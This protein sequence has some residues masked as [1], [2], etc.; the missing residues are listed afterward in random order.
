M[1]LTILLL[2]QQS[3][4][5]GAERVLDEVLYALEPDS[6]PIV[7]FPEDGPFAADVRRRGIETA[8]IPLGSYRSGP[9]SLADKI[10]F[11]PQ[12]LRCALRLSRV[13]RKQNVSLIY[14]N[15]PRCLVAGA[16]AARL[17]ARPSVFHLHMTMTRPADLWVA[18]R[19]ARH[20]TKIIACSQTAAMALSRADPRLGEKMQVIYN[21]VRKPM[22]AD[23]E[24]APR[25]VPAL[26]LGTPSRRVVGLVGRITR[27]KGHHV[28]LKAA[29]RLRNRGMDIHVVFVGAPEKNNRE[30][31]SYV[32]ALKCSARELGLEGRIHWTGYQEDPN[33]F[34]AL[35]DAVAIPS[36]VSEG[37]PMVAL[38][39]LQWGLPVVGS[40]V[41]GIPEIVHDGVNGFLVP[42]GDDEALADCLGRLLNSSEVRVR[43]QSGALAS[44][45]GRFSVESFRT[46]IRQVLFELSPDG[47]TAC[48]EIG[49]PDRALGEPA[50]R[51]AAQDREA[52]ALRRRADTSS[53]PWI[54]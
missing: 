12:S 18:S 11:G 43:L 14:I 31:A 32:H 40:G 30:D 46:R 13:I 8:L 5:S 9:K 29:L 20:V 48:A 7:A 44:V 23:N 50:K 41:G 42:P 36:T 22:A 45:D 51:G 52:C 15:S 47:K 53:L 2:E 35:F 25:A 34:Y 49:G 27:Q 10:A 19:A 38:E 26:S 16:L 17:T 33:A 1:G 39:A 6:R 3:W 54:T 24:G 21:P 37:L 28:L 4:R